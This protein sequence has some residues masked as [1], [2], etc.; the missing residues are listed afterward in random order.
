MKKYIYILV[1]ALTFATAQNA[2][3]FDPKDILGKLAGAAQQSTNNSSNESDESSDNGGGILGA[4]GSFVNNMTANKNFTVDDLVGTWT[5][6]GPCVSFQSDNALK[7]I[8]GAT[9]ASAVESKLEPYYNKLGFNKTSLTVDAEHSFELKMGLI[10]L[11]GIIEKNENDMLVF[12]FNAF[13]K[14]PLGKV[15]ANA[16]KSANQLSLTFDATKM[17]HVITTVA[18]KLNMST[19]N[20]L[21]SLLNSYDGIYMGFKLKG[22]K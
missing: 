3:A 4:L 17:I 2:N 5:Y 9:A 19:L 12:N 22:S 8:G 18:S 10:T 21:S 6:S 15:A 11:K 14:V 7:K 16:V 1:A 13:G 20:A